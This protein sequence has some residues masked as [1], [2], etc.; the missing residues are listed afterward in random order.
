MIDISTEV[1]MAKTT[2]SM[3]SAYSKTTLNENNSLGASKYILSRS[4]ELANLS[5]TKS[6]DYKLLLDK[7]HAG[8]RKLSPVVDLTRTSLTSIKNLVNNVETNE[9][10]A[11]G[12]D[13][14]SK[15]ISRTVTLADGQD[16]EDLA[17]YLTAYKPGTS[18]L[19]VYHKL[20]HAE[21]DDGIA[22]AS[23]VKMSQDTLTSITSDGIN[24]DDF[25]EYKYVCDSSKMTGGGG[26]YQYTN[27]S[28][29]T[30]TGYKH[31]AGLVINLYY[32]YWI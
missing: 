19:S 14:L 23:W 28:S 16:A 10:A 7:N 21:D 3:D 9:A 8:A 5:G 15:Y 1:K 30:F 13:A 2:A 20:V 18:T 22:D 11:S 27:S 6:V 17:V 25:K 12:G 26:E 32:Y 29:V 4:N 24:T 31:F